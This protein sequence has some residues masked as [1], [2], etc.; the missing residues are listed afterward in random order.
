MEGGSA[1]FGEGDDHIY[2]YYLAVY[3]SIC[4]LTDKV[5]PDSLFGRSRRSSVVLLAAFRTDLGSCGPLERDALCCR[6]PLPITSD[7]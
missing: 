4:A 2:Y 3:L 1:G 5:C 7:R 6:D